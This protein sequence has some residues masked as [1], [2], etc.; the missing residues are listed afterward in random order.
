MVVGT[1]WSTSAFDQPS[2]TAPTELDALG[3]HLNQ[4][5]RPGGLLFALRCGAERAQ[6]LARSRLVTST[7]VVAAIA[8]LVLLSI[9]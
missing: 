6:R 3:Q 8:G 2:D 4:C 9:G 1:N 5:R 7:V